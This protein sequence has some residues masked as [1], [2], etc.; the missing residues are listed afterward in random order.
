MNTLLLAWEHGR[1]E[2]HEVP[3]VL[4]VL[5]A[6]LVKFS[7]HTVDECPHGGVSVYSS[8]Q[9]T[10]K[11]PDSTGEGMPTRTAAFTAPEARGP[12]FREVF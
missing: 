2:W 8:P 1:T 7:H 3:G 6:K 12:C 9:K 10:G 5:S 11:S 4:S